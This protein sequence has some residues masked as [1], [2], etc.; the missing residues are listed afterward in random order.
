MSAIWKTRI[1][2]KHRG[3]RRSR[4]QPLTHR[5]WH[6]MIQHR[7]FSRRSPARSSWLPRLCESILI[8]VDVPTTAVVVAPRPI[9]HKHTHHPSLACTH[10]HI[11]WSRVPQS[12]SQERSTHKPIDVR[13][14]P[15]AVASQ[16]VRACTLGGLTL[17]LGSGAYGEQWCQVHME[18]VGAASSINLAG[19]KEASSTPANLMR[20]AK[21]PFVF[22]HRDTLLN[23]YGV[24]ATGQPGPGSRKWRQRR[25]LSSR[26]SSPKR[27]R[28]CR[29]CDS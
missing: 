24:R 20:T 15:I 2:L 23:F 12:H 3:L 18:G 9:L 25:W 19:C 17:H 16:E 14:L 27:A 26:R 7:R 21:I 4:F 8:V 10:A 13:G 5:H 1:A 6:A 29:P 22:P 28:S 11:A